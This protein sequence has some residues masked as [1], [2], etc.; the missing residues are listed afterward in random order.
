VQLALLLWAFL[1][2]SVEGLPPE[3]PREGTVLTV[4]V[5]TNTAYLFRDGALLKKGPVAT[6]MDKVL[7]KGSRIWLFRTPRGRHEVL[8]KIANPVWTKP[9]WAYIEEGQRVPSYD[10]PSRKVRGKLGKYALSLG[11][12]ILIH[13]TDDP[14]SIGKKA[15]HG[16]IR[17]GSD[18]LRVVWSEAPV[19]TPVYLFDSQPSFPLAE[20]GMSDLDFAR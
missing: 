17:M 3:A 2:A 18:M 9:D 20:S 19:G 13:G 15:S 8:Q 4:D 6:G 1:T 7:R 16:C 11:E 12:G 14:K 10:H 5:S